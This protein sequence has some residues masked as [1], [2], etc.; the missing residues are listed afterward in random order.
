MFARWIERNVDL[1]MLCESIIKFFERK[2]LKV[3]REHVENGCSIVV[4]P[5]RVLGLREE[6]VISITGNANDFEV[7]L[8]A[9]DKSR[10]LRNL[11]TITSLFG[12][13]FFALEGLKSLEAIEKLE[14]EFW[15]FMDEAVGYLT[16]SANIKK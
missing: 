15:L 14:K 4:M 11:G 10:S 12:G 5:R 9:G 8:V 6:I 16:G 2:R 1:L 13:G 7:R 3:V